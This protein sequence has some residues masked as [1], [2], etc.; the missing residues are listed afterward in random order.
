MVRVHVP[1]FVQARTRNWYAHRSATRSMAGRS[2]RSK[3]ARWYCRLTVASPPSRSSVMIAGNRNLPE[4]RHQQ[5][6]RKTCSDRIT[7]SKFQRRPLHRNPGSRKN[8]DGL[9]SKLRLE[10]LRHNV[11]QAEKSSALC[12]MVLALPH[13]L[14]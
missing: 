7:H 8:V 11:T 2:A 12:K 9:E 13:M 3:D 14:R 4:D 1:S 10:L 6:N 5:A